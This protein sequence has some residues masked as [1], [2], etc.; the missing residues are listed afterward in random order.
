MI[1]LPANEISDEPYSSK[2]LSI[3]VEVLVDESGKLSSEELLKERLT[4][5]DLAW[6]C[7]PQMFEKFGNVRK[8]VT[9]LLFTIP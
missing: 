7:R 5:I 1:F 9:L 2:L 6:I 3:G 8:K 4:I